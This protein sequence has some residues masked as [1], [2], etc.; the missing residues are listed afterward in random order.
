MGYVPELSEQHQT[1]VEAEM[2]LRG[3]GQ[4]PTSKNWA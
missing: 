3:T 1:G 2:I 4:K